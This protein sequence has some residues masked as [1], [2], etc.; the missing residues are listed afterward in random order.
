M[1]QRKTILPPQVYDRAYELGL[2]NDT[3]FGRFILPTE[4]ETETET[5]KIIVRLNAKLKSGEIR[6]ENP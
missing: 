2:I 6:V 5:E 4:T 3:F 1:K